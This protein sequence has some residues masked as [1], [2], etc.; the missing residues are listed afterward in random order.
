MNPI[1]GAT[2]NFF[3]SD[4]SNFY[5]NLKFEENPHFFLRTWVQG[6][7]EDDI[8]YYRRKMYL[9]LSEKHWNTSNSSVL[10]WVIL[11]WVFQ[12]PNSSFSI[13]Q[14]TYPRSLACNTIQLSSA[15]NPVGT[16]KTNIIFFIHFWKPPQWGSS[17][18]SMRYINKSE[19]K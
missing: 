8:K 14:C 17:V 16:R 5:P 15:V 10:L 1:N 7:T 6:R 18:A 19:I 9:S 11:P 2:L 4:I 3:L 13:P 12:L